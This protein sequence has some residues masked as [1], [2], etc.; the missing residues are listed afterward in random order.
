MINNI[1]MLTPEYPK[2]TGG[3]G[4]GTYVNYMARQFIEYNP[5]IKVTVLSISYE[6]YQDYIE[7]GIRVIRLK[8][9]RNN[10][11]NRFWKYTVW[12]I[13]N[14][15]NY[16]VIEDEIFGG[17]T[18]FARLL[19]GKKY[20]YIARLH[21]T[22]KE[23]MV[24][25]RYKSFFKIISNKITG[26]F[27]KY[28]TKRAKLAI[29][30]SSMIETAV[31]FIWNLDLSKTQVLPCAFISAGTKKVEVPEEFNNTDYFLFFGRI[32]KKKGSDVLKKLVPTLLK[33]YPK[34]KF[35]F[36]GGDLVNM[37]GGFRGN[38]RVVFV[39]FIS[40][41]AKWRGIISKAKIVILPSLF[42]SFLYT[43]VESICMGIP[44]IVSRSCGVSQ[45]LNL[46]EEYNNIASNPSDPETYLKL[47]DIMLKNYDSSL[48]YA[49]LQAES[50]KSDLSSASVAKKY[51]EL[52]GKY[53]E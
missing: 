6:K 3:G 36:V 37:K 49:K 51:L 4:I 53:Y 47:V 34:M 12:L 22:S 18:F 20:K 10:I 8:V 24:L 17:W 44:T 14:Y 7:D 32:Q 35:V 25:E 5:K 46:Y 13:K 26:V 52:I 19:I 15:S 50:L 43:A 31:S 41:P 45:F 9:Y 39:D 27:E 1:L 40:E 2:E 29:F 11:I 48:K 16:D 33:K 42:E 21:G 23:L 28:L 30:E 38:K